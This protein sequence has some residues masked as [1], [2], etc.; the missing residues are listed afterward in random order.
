VMVASKQA[1]KPKVSFR[2]DGSNSPEN[3]GWLFVHLITA[4]LCGSL[5]WKPPTC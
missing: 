1:S 5:P 2:P 3:Y 4:R